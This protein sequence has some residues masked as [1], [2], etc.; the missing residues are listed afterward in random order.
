LSASRTCS[1]VAM[2]D[3]SGKRRSARHKAGPIEGGEILRT[4]GEYEAGSLSPG[5]ALSD[6]GR[7]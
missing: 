5:P 4:T 6:A 3:K 7:G 2:K 1:S